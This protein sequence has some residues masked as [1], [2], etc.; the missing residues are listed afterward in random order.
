[1]LHGNADEF[2]S[3]ISMLFGAMLSAV[4]V[5]YL[6]LFGSDAGPE[7]EGWRRRV[8]PHAELE[9]WNGHGHS[10]HLVDPDRFARRM[11]AFAASALARSSR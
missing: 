4:R 1:M 11:R 3:A 2:H 5:P 8:L 6:D 7:Y 9:L 10:L